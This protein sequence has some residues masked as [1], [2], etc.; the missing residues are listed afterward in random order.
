MHQLFWLY[1]NTRSQSGLPEVRASLLRTERTSRSR[2]CSSLKRSL[3]PQVWP[4]HHH[5]APTPPP[6]HTSI[7]LTPHKLFS[8]EETQLQ[9][10]KT[11]TLPPTLW[12][13]PTD[14]PLSPR[15]KLSLLFTRRSHRLLSILCSSST[16]LPQSN[17]LKLEFAMFHQPHYSPEIPLLPLSFS[18]ATV[19]PLAAQNSW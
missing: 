11:N 9:P 4:T 16:S 18:E 2:L 19:D 1:N 8:L 5:L 14:P 17:F 12:D 6:R 3:P 7:S 15:N 10:S 13:C